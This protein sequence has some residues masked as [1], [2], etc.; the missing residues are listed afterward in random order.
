MAAPE[1]LS[2]RPVIVLSAQLADA[3]V[4][5]GYLLTQLAQ[6]TPVTVMTLFTH[7]Q[8]GNPTRTARAFLDTRNARRAP[9]LYTQRRTEDILA[10]RSVNITGV[11]FG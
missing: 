8:A 3:A 9:A 2:D 11:H 5:C 7:S 1:S 10:L 6:T 4:S